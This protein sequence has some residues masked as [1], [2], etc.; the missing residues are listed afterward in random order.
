MATVLAFFTSLGIL[1]QSSTV[2]LEKKF[3][4]TSS[5]AAW[6]LKFLGPSGSTGSISQRYGSGSFPFL[7]GV[8]RTEI[9]LANKIL[10]QNFSQKIN[11]LKVPSYEI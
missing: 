9:M 7:K 1:F 6:G 11:F 5:L 10:T 4:L 2:L 3:L 8:E